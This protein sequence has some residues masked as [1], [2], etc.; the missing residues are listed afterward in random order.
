MRAIQLH[1]KTNEDIVGTVL[2]KGCANYSEVTN[3]WDEYQ[4][5]N[6]FDLENEP[7]IYD[8]YLKNQNIC[9][10]LELDFYQP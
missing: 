2:L 9:E 3:A 8:F 10:V 1:D 4:K 6:N 5:T 7:D